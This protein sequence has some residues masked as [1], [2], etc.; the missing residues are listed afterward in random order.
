[1]KLK[2]MHKVPGILKIFLPTQYVAENSVTACDLKGPLLTITWDPGV[3]T[4][5]RLRF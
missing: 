1:M 4:T 5:L 3:R 2:K